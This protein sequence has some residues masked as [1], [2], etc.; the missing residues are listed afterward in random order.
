M[1]LKRN[2]GKMLERDEWR[3]RNKK[4]KLGESK[5]KEMGAERKTKAFKEFAQG[6]GDGVP[7]RLGV[8]NIFTHI[9]TQ[10]HTHILCTV[11]KAHGWTHTHT[12]AVHTLH[13]IKPFIYWCVCLKMLSEGELSIIPQHHWRKTAGWEAWGREGGKER[14]GREGRRE[15]IFVCEATLAACCSSLASSSHL[16]GSGV[17]VEDT[18]CE[19]WQGRRL[20]SLFLSLSLSL[21][22]SHSP[23]LFVSPPFFSLSITPSPP[24][25]RPPAVHAALPPFL[26]HL[27]LCIPPP[28]HTVYLHLVSPTIPINTPI[29]EERAKA[30][31]MKQWKIRLQ[32]ACNEIKLKNGVKRMR[33]ETMETLK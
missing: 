25:R 7:D 9:H 12:R 24:H 4:G 6:S 23:H 1:R 13:Y 18:H 8:E 3:Q 14:R 27:N 33:L 15:E 5:E 2:M 22:L 26:P 17:G 30:T 32:K 16:S 29:K 10:T 28:V 21:S 11:T 31:E 19:Y 20:W